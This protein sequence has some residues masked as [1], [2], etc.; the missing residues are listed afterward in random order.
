MEH[1]KAVDTDVHSLPQTQS[2]RLEE[3]ESLPEPFHLSSK[4]APATYLSPALLDL[5]FQ[6]WAAC[7]EGVVI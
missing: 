5:A 4:Q 2:F 3:A 6:G 7:F 1:Y